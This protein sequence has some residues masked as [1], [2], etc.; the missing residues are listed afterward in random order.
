MSSKVTYHRAKSTEDLNAIL[1]LQTLNLRHLLP[2]E[3]KQK[4]GFVTLQHD[5]NILKQMNDA[6]AHCIAKC[7]GEVVGYALAMLQDFKNDIPLL[8]PMFL[9]IDKA[10]SA[11]NINSNYIAMGQICVAINQRGKG[12]FRGLYKF[13]ADELKK[14]FDAIITEVDTQN[15][16]SSLAHKAIGF[17]VVKTYMSN[18]QLWEIISLDL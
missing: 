12:V 7:D 3:Q 6:C 13:M 4:E 10:V 15:K 2:E 8:K 18:N 11:Q 9:E 16:R 5:F 17:T 1:K 14:E